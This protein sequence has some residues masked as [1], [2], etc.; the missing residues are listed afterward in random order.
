MRLTQR[1]HNPRTHKRPVPCRA[2]NATGTANIG[3][4][5]VECTKCGGKGWTMPRRVR[6]NVE[7]ETKE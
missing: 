1:R 7:R 5:D 3:G 2:C 6:V 4:W